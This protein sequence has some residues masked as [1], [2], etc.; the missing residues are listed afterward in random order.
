VILFNRAVQ[1]MDFTIL[2]VDLFEMTGLELSPVLKALDVKIIN[3]RDI[4]AVLNILDENAQTVNALVWTV[5]SDDGQDF[6]DIARIKSDTK[7]KD[8]PVLII[9]KFTDKKFIIKA[10]EL[11]A[12]EF[13][14]KP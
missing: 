2:S 6:R 3:V 7:Y 1:I 13:V 14:A 9:S 12:T 4:N 10:I 8:I 11:G 5:N